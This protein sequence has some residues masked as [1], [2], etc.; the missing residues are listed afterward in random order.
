MRILRPGN[1]IPADVRPFVNKHP[2]ML[3]KVCAL[4]EYERTEFALNAVKDLHQEQEDKIKVNF[5]V[6]LRMIVMFFVNSRVLIQQV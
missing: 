2:E 5:F 1:P 3:V 4:I 6:K